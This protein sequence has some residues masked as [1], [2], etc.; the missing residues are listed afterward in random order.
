[1]LDRLSTTSTLATAVV[2]LPTVVAANLLPLIGVIAWGWNL[3]TL[4][5]LY[6]LEGVATVLIAALKSLFAER[7]STGMPS[8][9]EPLH[10]LRAKRGGWR[11]HDRLPPVYPR[12]VPIA[13]SI[14][15]VWA[16]SVLLLSVLYWLSLDLPVP[17]SA[18]LALG[19]GGLVFSHAAEFA[20]DYIGDAEYREV[21]A[22]ELAATPALL[23]GVVLLL[24]LVSFDAGRSSALAV[25]VVVVLGK[26][27]VSTYRFSVIHFDRLGDR[28]ESLLPDRDRSEPPP[29]IPLPDAPV[30]DRVSVDT[31]AVLAG[32]I[33]AIGYGFAN[34]AGMVVLGVF[35]FSLLA[36]NLWI[37][38]VAVIPIAVVVAARVLSYYLRYGT[39][40]Y[41]R[42]GDV[43]VAY[44][45]VLAEPQWIAAVY[46][47]DFSVQNLI[48][49]RI[50]GTGTLA[51]S[52]VESVDRGSVRFGPVTDLDAAIE[53]LDLP[54]RQTERPDRDPAV[55][56]AAT[57]LAATFLVFPGALFFSPQVT[58]GTAAGITLVFAPFLLLPVG[59]LLWAG[60][61]RI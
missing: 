10:E 13:A 9:V 23:S 16:V 38:A 4:L 18:G 48:V 24:G 54:V 11:P 3:G 26:T 50:L 55:V 33:A 36:G 57:V 58:D 15:G 43:V 5:V 61:S 35:A 20:V 1:M 34:R 27:A 39:I 30:S 37:A 2:G 29:E 45:T 59:V 44:D 56:V 22:A 47:A 41:Q 19:A 25:L 53:T 52:G 21:S 31:R 7:G 46:G 60:L 28:L 49:D 40:E 42:R 6:W 8:R 12:N 14:L 32:S 51:I 17:L